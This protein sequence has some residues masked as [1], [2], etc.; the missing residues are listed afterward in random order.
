MIRINLLEASAKRART[1]KT[2]EMFGASS[3]TS[4]AA[5]A[6]IS[7]LV[8]AVILL[9]AHNFYL[10]HQANSLAA[11]MTAARQE[12][13]RLQ[14]VRREFQETTQRRQLL[15]QR[16]AMINGLKQSQSGPSALLAALRQA[17]D[18]APSVWL[19][20]VS[21]KAGVLTLHG[22]ALNFDAVANLISS[23]QQTGYFSKIALRSSA[24]Q[25][26]QRGVWPFAFVLTAQPA[27]PSGLASAGADNAAGNRS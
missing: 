11:Q 14:A 13:S 2:P 15:E 10:S 16:I 3:G 22:S 24:Q 25:S 4:P 12:A 20:A 1:A 8:L 9:I 6:G 27:S 21:E 5:L 23:L 18:G 17:V 26:E 7:A 19:D